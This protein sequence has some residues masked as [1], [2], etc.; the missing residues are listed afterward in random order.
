MT[1]KELERQ[2]AQAAG[3]KK[4]QDLLAVFLFLLLLPYTCSALARAGRDS[5]VETLSLPGDGRVIA[6]EQ[7]NGVK[8]I[9]EEEF[10]VGALAASIPAQYR[11][12]TK[13]AQAVILRSMAFCREKEAL[14]ARESGLEYMDPSQRRLLWGEDFEENEKAFG[15]A[16][17]ETKGQVL[18]Y[19]Q[20]VVSPPFFRLSAGKT[21]SG[22]EIFGQERIVWCH[23]IECPGDENAPDFLQ[24]SEWDRDSFA[25]V[26]ASEGMILPGENAYILLTRDSAGY[27]L[28]VSCGESRM[29][30]ERFRQL[31][32]L[33]SSCFSLREEGGKII[34]QTKGIGHGLG[35]DQY[36]ADLLAEQG[37]GYVELLKWFF[38][39]AEVEER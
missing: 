6:W 10:L 11:P 29:E 4:L 31:F 21:R 22:A 9:P 38:A 28:E 34:L 36:S 1:E 26:L 35:F 3:R 39:G 16:V 32:D 2:A 25:R 33:A 24:E 17:R 15:E 12:E 7:E 20:E 13:K 14:S 19:A 37:K 18:T 30:G 27:V 8:R 23:S 5:A